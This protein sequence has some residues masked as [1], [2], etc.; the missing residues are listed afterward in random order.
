VGPEVGCLVGVSVIIFGA[1][2][3]FE[4]GIIEGLTV[5]SSKRVVVGA[6]VVI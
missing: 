4:V 6:A 3:G 1:R 5:G 2:V